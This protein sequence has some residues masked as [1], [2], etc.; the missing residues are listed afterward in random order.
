MELR[1]DEGVKLKPYRCSAG[2][3]TVGVGHNLD[4]KGISEAVSD[5]MLS[6]DIADAMA[7]LDR[8]LPWWRKL[9]GVRQRVLVNMTFNL[10]IGGLLGFRN[11]LRFVQRGQYLDAAQ[12]MLQSK[13]A[14]QVGKRAVRLATMMRDG[15]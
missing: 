9:D 4:A 2:A 5:L 12:G 3:L 15:G 7:D 14:R 11:T 10:G 1:R 8:E 6:E 13:W